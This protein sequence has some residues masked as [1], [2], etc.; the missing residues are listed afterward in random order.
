MDMLINLFN[1]TIGIIVG[2]F[3]FCFLSY[4]V[5]TS[6]PESDLHKFTLIEVL[7]YNLLLLLSSLIVNLRFTNVIDRI[8]F[9]ILLS[10]LLFHAH[11]DS[12][13]NEVYRIFSLFLWGTGLLYTIIKIFILKCI[14][15]EPIY[16]GMF[17]IGPIIFILIM[18]FTSVLCG[19]LHGKGDGYILIGNA[20]FM[21]FLAI[22]TGMF[23]VEPILI[24][25]ICAAFVLII[26]N[27]KKISFKK[28]R[29]KQRV[30][31]APAV[32]AGALMTIL[33]TAFF[34]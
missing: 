15:L 21:Q 13:T 33:G 8:F 25:Y 12:K 19:W 30:A 10:V 7:F 17:F 24:H 11:T 27:P 1:N 26:T 22:E 16:L 20:L 9:M 14:I 5:E 31:Y 4:I 28:A 18:F 6:D 32:F 34:M 2:T 23:S 29:M 3:I